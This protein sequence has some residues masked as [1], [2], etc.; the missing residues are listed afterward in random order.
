VLVEVIRLDFLP[1]GMAHRRPF[2]RLI[3]SRRPI[4]T[5]T[6]TVKPTKPPERSRSHRNQTG[7]LRRNAHSQESTRCERFFEPPYGVSLHFQ[8]PLDRMTL[9][10][11]TLPARGCYS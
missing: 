5:S 3:S 2:P 6:N 8:R 11:T 1:V 9:T 4:T 10:I 7:S